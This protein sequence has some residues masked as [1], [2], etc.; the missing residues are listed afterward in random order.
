MK[1]DEYER[2]KELL[3]KAR[4]ALAGARVGIDLAGTDQARRDCWSKIESYW[5]DEIH[6]LESVLMDYDQEHE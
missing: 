1:R 5:V 4:M 6:Y 2:K 3:V